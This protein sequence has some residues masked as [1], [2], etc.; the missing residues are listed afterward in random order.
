MCGICGIARRGQLREGDA[1]SV[2]AMMNAMIHRGPDGEGRYQ[3]GSVS[4]GMRR[5]SIIDVE[6]SDQPLYNEDGSLVLIANAEIYN[7]VE[8]RS[9]LQAQGH[10]FSSNGDC[11]TILHL[12]ERDGD[13]CVESL[14]GMFA[15]ALWDVCRRRLLLARDRMG[16]KPLYIYEKD[17]GIVFASE[18]K[19]LLRSGYVPFEIEPNCVNLYFHYQYVPE[20]LTLL[21]SVRKLAAAH[22]MS[23]DVDSWS[24]DVKCYWNM[25]D[26]PPLR[27][28]PAALIREELERVSEL[29]LRSDVPVGVALSGGID[30]GGVASLAVKHCPGVLHAFTVGYPGCPDSDERAAA[31]ALAHD[32]NMPFHE[33]EVSLEEMARSFENLIYLRDDPVSDIAGYGYYAVMKKARECSVP[34]VIQGQGGDELFWGYD[35]VR[36]AA[37]ESLMKKR[38]SRWR[39]LALPEYLYYA[40][41]TRKMG[42]ASRCGS[43]F[44]KGRDGWWLFSAHKRSPA[45]RLRFIEKSPNYRI[46][47]ERVYGCYTPEFVD[48]LDRSRPNSLF[49]MSQPW[50]HPDISITRLICQTYL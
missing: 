44:A 30:S 42:N 7:Y 35:H 40:L 27:G 5:L 50:R 46:A 16:E 18:M 41:T 33:V 3:N 14:E 45:N 48:R 21:K 37:I 31:K 29:I 24:V 17:R 49:T 11:E 26:A 38:L 23:V 15:F 47:E 8:L 43:L 10:V 34:V 6:G 1:A 9:E 19:A 12:Y 20:P 36:R 22:V 13:R 25:E 32:L 28:N 4:L 2:Q 39:Y